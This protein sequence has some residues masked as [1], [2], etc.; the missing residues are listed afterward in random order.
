MR[1][2][3]TR[4]LFLLFFPF[5]IKIRCGVENLIDRN[6]EPFNDAAI[7]KTECKKE[8]EHRGNQGEGNQRDKKARLEFRSG[9]LLLP[10]NPY[11]DKCP[12]EDEAEDQESQE[13]ER[14]KCI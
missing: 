8:Q 13:D 11:L 7:D 3:S 14:G 1:Q 10:F 9:L 4:Q 2:D 5:Q 12:K 6:A